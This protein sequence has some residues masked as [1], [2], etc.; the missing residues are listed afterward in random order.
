MDHCGASD[1][2]FR[3][4]LDQLGDHDGFGLVDTEGARGSQVNQLLCVNELDLF[5]GGCL[6]LENLD[7]PELQSSSIRLRS[8]LLSAKNRGSRPLL[9]DLL[10]DP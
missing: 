8:M 10:I 3:E 6:F 5:I 1:E 9:S 4:G 7:D 2:V